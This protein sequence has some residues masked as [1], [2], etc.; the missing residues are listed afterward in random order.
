MEDTRSLNGNQANLL[1]N[2]FFVGVIPPDGT[3]L[4]KVLWMRILGIDETVDSES[5]DRTLRRDG[6]IREKFVGVEFIDACHIRR[7]IAFGRGESKE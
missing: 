7:I 4:S 3:Q 6:I 1:P 5:F 2:G